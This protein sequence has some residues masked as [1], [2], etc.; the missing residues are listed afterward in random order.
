DPASYA[1]AVPWDEVLGGD[2]SA[3][4]E[5][6]ADG[7]G[8][9][10][11]TVVANRTGRFPDSGSR[12]TQDLTLAYEVVGEVEAIPLM[13]A[14]RTTM[15]VRRDTVLAWAQANAEIS[16][17]SDLELEAGDEP[18]DDNDLL[19][20]LQAWLVSTDSPGGVADFLG[21]I[22]QSPNLLQTRSGA[23]ED[24]SF[25]APRWAFDYLRLLAFVSIP[26]AIVVYA[27]AVVEERRRIAVA[28]ALLRRM[29]V[30]R[31]S[32]S[33]ALAIEVAALIALAA[34]LGLATAAV[35]TFT[36]AGQFDPL[37]R[38]LPQLTPVIAAGAF[39]LAALIAFVGATVV[40]WSARRSAARADIAEVL[41]V[42]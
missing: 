26:L 37:P 24:A 2:L 1:A 36:V 22:G 40:W 3:V 8:E 11:P 4:L 29:G 13:A 39:A 6:L 17:W 7:T 21:S 42:G 30:G 15:L 18:V 16:G 35:L 25:S 27:F 34:L 33:A 20:A 31:S 14:R 5:L 38:L 32:A 12:R 23:L 10:V 41:R 28:H 19:L 9:R